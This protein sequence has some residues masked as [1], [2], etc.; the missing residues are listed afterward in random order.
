MLSI[1][2]LYIE[3]PFIIMIDE[4]KFKVTHNDLL[5]DSQGWSIEKLYPCGQMHTIHLRVIGNVINL[6][7]LAQL[8]PNSK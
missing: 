2:W 8:D 4:D 7:D 6:D 3:V 1:V 5:P